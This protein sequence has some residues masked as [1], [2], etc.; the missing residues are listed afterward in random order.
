MQNTG[1]NKTRHLKFGSDERGSMLPIMA[2]AIIAV[3][4]LGGLAIDMGRMYDLQNQLQMTADVSALA[5]AML[6]PDAT[7]SRAAANSLAAKNMSSA[8]DK[9]V[10]ADS[11]IV[12]GVWN[13]ATRAFTPGGTPNA[14]RITTRRAAA[15]TN[16]VETFFAPVIGVDQANLQATATAAAI[17]GGAPWDIII[18]QDVTSS[19]S[20]EIADARVADQTL[21]T[22]LQQNTSSTSRVGLAIFTGVG[23]QL[24]N[25]QTLGDSY[26]ALSSKISTLKTCG[27]TGMPACS[28]TNIAAGLT[29]AVNMYT[30]SPS[31]SGRK[32]AIILV[33]DGEP[34]PA[35][36]KPA[37]IAAADEASLLGLSVFT[38]FYDRDN[39]STQRTFLAS[40]VRGDGVALAT[41]NASQLS[42]L[43]TSLCTSHAPGHAQLVN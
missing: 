8:D 10:L 37:A 33:S 40:L 4:G 28:G 12:L 9:D 26:A 25:W 6:L 16:P 2:G 35:S 15:N 27:N 19:F 18:V 3:F 20:N 32:R 17:P 14:V 41:P 11:D 22:C 43:T 21:L 29:T 24:S 38:I 36:L 13:T 31:Q 34:N 7:T 23:A 39:S 5:A 42:A 30:A 1:E